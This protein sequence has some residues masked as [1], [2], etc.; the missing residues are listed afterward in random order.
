MAHARKAEC[1]NGLVQVQQ[2]FST[3]PFTTKY[4]YSACLNCYIPSDLR[5]QSGVDWGSVVVDESGF[6]S[7]VLRGHCCCGRGCR[8]EG[9]R[10]LQTGCTKASHIYPAGTGTSAVPEQ[11]VLHALAGRVQT[12]GGCRAALSASAALMAQYEL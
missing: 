10:E 3:I 4:G 1:C 9:M 8:G 11:S 12:A 2:C 5:L 7:A 6:R